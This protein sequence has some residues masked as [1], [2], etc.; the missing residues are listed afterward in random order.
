MATIEQN[1]KREDRFVQSGHNLH[2][3]GNEFVKHDHGS[4]KTKGTN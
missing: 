2:K 1:K 4:P 3:S